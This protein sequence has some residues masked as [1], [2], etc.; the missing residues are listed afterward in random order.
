M[1][2]KPL[3]VVEVEYVA[4]RA[5]RKFMEWDEPIPDFS[6][7]IPHILESCLKQPFVTFDK[8][9]LYRGLSGKASILFYLMNKNHPFR[10]GNKRIAVTTLLYC[11]SINGK[12]LSLSND[13]LY[14]FAREVS[15]SESKEKDKVVSQ[16]QKF[17]GAHIVPLK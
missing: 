10:N 11:L 5:A 16:I 2:S 1:R 17:I 13:A 14:L 3:T 8:K 4:Y 7:R 6:E 9:N 12:W 15:G